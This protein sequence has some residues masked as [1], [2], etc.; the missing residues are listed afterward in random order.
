[1]GRRKRCTGARTRPPASRGTPTVS[2]PVPSGRS[3]RPAIGLHH[4]RCRLFRSNPS[5]SVFVFSMVHEPPRSSFSFLAAR[6][7]ITTQFFNRIIDFHNFSLP[8]KLSCNWYELFIRIPPRIGGAAA[9]AGALHP[10]HTKRTESQN[11]TLSEKE[12]KG[13]RRICRHRPENS[14]ESA[15]DCEGCGRRRQF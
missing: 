7:S 4:L 3:Y 1:M 10:R 6:L 13:V 8:R 14:P 5:I 9:S 12:R 15:L 2:P 11:R